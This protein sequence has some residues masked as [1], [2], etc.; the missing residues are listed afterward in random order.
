MNFIAER[1]KVNPSATVG[2]MDQV[3]KLQRAGEDVISMSA[4]EPDFVTPE[5]IRAYAKQALDERYTFYSD[6]PGLMELREAIAEKLQRDN[7]IEADPEDEIVVTVGGKEAIYSAMMATINPGDDVIVPD[8]YWV[9]YVPCIE[10]CG[11]H[12]VYLPLK[13]SEGFRI[14]ASQ[15]ERVLTTRT[16][17]LI[18]NS[19]NNP[20]G[21]V[22]AKSD[23][24]ALADLAKQKRLLVLSDELYERILF[25]RKTLQYCVIC[26]HEGT[27]HRCQRILKS[28]SHDRMATWL[29][30]S[31]Q[32]HRDTRYC[33][34]QSSSHRRMHF[35]ST[36]RSIGITRRKNGQVHQGNGS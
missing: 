11:G 15:V 8:P 4:G 12:P 34:S 19:P 14:S 33:N 28:N 26:W 9:S 6:T 30:D 32:K 18:L 22:A 35:R 3:K 23:I 2:I 13:E 5:H 25:E 7:D 31:A 1:A 24:G 17:M 27:F 16:K 20:T 21:S 10:L 36:R 29:L